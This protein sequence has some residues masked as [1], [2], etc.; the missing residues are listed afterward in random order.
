[1]VASVYQ[2][3]QAVCSRESS[4][5]A[6][7]YLKF[8]RYRK[9]TRSVLFGIPP[10]ALIKLN[11]PQQ[12]IGLIMTLS[13]VMMHCDSTGKLRPGEHRMAGGSR[14]RIA[15]SSLAVECSMWLALVAGSSLG[16]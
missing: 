9:G 10:D 8:A 14:R 15:G 12:A 2:S 3:V 5:A 11:G 6:S 13:L 7:Q 16:E 1:M 4:G